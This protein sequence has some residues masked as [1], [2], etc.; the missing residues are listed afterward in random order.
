MGAILAAL[1]LVAHPMG[2]GL[3]VAL[4]IYIHVA[5]SVPVR[6]RWLVLV[7]ALLLRRRD[8]LRS[9]AFFPHRVLARHQSPGDE[10]LRSVGSFSATPTSISRSPLLPSAAC[11]FLVAAFVDHNRENLAPRIRTPIE[12]WTIF[13]I[14]ATMV[15]GRDLASGVHRGGQRDQ[16][17]HHHGHRDSRPLCFGRRRSAQVDFRRPQRHR[18]D[19]LRAAIS[20]HRR[21]STAWSKKSTLSLPALPYGSKVS[22]TIDHGNFSRINSRHF[23]DRACIGR[24]FT[25]S[26]YEPGSKQFRVRLSPEGS[27]IVSPRR[28]RS[29]TRH[30][31]VREQDLAALP[32]L[33]TR[34]PRSDQ[35]RNSPASPPAKKTGASATINRSSNVIESMDVQLTLAFRESKIAASSAF[36]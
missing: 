29:R 32:D 6:Y 26:N 35:A 34:R 15:P 13:V 12:L 28:P 8:P 11:A 14:A 10:R 20:R 21:A 33:S 1:S 27:S 25:Y 31:V 36:D 9:A 17:P 2:F 7:G 22:Y 19:F 4:V 3:L 30:Y 16:Q 18:P 24:C 23:V 5:E